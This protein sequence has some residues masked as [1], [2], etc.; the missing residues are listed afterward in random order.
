MSDERQI[1][2]IKYALA[3]IYRSDYSNEETVRTLMSNVSKEAL[4][5][6]IVDAFNRGWISSGNL[7]IDDDGN[8]I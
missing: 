3:G 2:A 4:A 6:F 1:E 8:V 5:E 7:G